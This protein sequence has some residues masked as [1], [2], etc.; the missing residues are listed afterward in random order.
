MK[1]KKKFKILHQI[2]ILMKMTIVKILNILLLLLLKKK[3]QNFNKRTNN[4][5]KF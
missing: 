1:Q 4:D 3:K 5:I 2:K